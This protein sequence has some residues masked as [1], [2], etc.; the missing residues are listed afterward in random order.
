MK[1]PIPFGK[2]YL[3]ERVNVGGMAEVFKAKTYG[4]EGFQRL[5]AVKRIL[6][7]IAEDQEFIRMFID[8]AK[9]AVQLNHA[10]IAQIFD[11]GN[12]GGSYYIA[13]EFIHGKDLR[14]IFDRS[15]EIA[16]NMPI[17]QASFI[18]MKICEGLDYAH[19]KRDPSGRE[20]GL[21]H[22]DISPQNVLISYEGEIKIIDFGIAK[23]AGRASKTQAGILKGKFGYM[24][25]EQVRGMPLDRRSD[26]FSVGIVLYEL[27]TGERLFVG[28]SD[29]STLEKVRNVE[30]LPPSTYNRRIPEE[31]E[32]I[33]L[34]ALAR[35]VEDRYQTAI[36]LH[37][38]LQAFMYSA[39]EFYSGKDLAAWMKRIFARELEEETRKLKEFQHIPPPTQ[40]AAPPPVP[41]GYDGRDERHED[42]QDFIDPFD[43][44]TPDSGLD[45]DDE[46]VE[47]QLYDK[48]P[49]L[50]D[51]LDFHPTPAA[52]PTAAPVEFDRPAKGQLKRT[53]MGIGAVKVP[54]VEPYHADPVAAFAPEPS[55]ADPMAAFAP[56]PEPFDEIPDTVSEVDGF[57]SDLSGYGQGAPVLVETPTPSRRAASQRPVGTWIAL[58][59]V[60]L[61]V[62]GAGVTAVWFFLL[63]AKQKGTVVLNPA[64]V[65]G[66]T[67]YVD[68]DPVEVKPGEPK[69]LQLAPGKHVLMAEAPGHKPM[70]RTFKVR[71]GQRLILNVAPAL[72]GAVPG[73][74][75]GTIKVTSNP[76]GAVVILNGK[77]LKNSKTPLLVTDLAPGIYR[78]KVKMPNYQDWPVASE[79]V[80]KLEGGVVAEV[81]AELQPKVVLLIVKSSAKNAHAT[82]FKNGV[83]LF[84]H[85]SL[86]SSYKLNPDQ[87]GRYSL[88]V[89]AKGYE[90]FSRDLQFQGQPELVV[91]AE[92]E[93]SSSA[94]V[95]VARHA[96]P[97]HHVAH[98]RVVEPR[99][100]RHVEPARPR[101][102][103]RPRVTASGAKGFIRVGSRP[104]ANV[105][106]DGHKVGATPQRVKV[107]AGPHTVKLVNPEFNLR[108]VY[109][110]TVG[111]GASKT[112]IYRK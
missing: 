97:I 22:R 21:V 74:G 71:S 68:G 100:V 63:R 82:L 13:M 39:G 80:V 45:W 53:L 107:S 91:E 103:P 27:L 85:R 104:W 36:D 42:A 108:K 99:H 75:K 111:A 95:A 101:P 17:A 6:P 28:E 54:A 86:P 55:H 92:L 93:R 49:T 44:S 11:L 64:S 23:A 62:V 9:I 16:E 61:L 72:P 78:V 41:A 96:R 48:Q 29:F 69:V 38:E 87:T 67:V 1:R 37:D 73:A 33:V 8:E 34:K 2:Y 35:D 7:N 15:H 94:Q 26:V 90:K 98:P 56:E 14:A 18:V 89:R 105:Y 52:T 57:V 3:L 51:E 77:E 32:R 58:A 65:V 106:I 84:Q 50:D 109:H 30:I 46:E 79:K 10:N 66:L 47:T 70:E 83:A 25:P 4:V 76:P 59:L 20:L 24:S 12:E 5:I 19:N 88:E 112:I 40:Q 81:K 60:G 110:V 102:R 31:L 43:P